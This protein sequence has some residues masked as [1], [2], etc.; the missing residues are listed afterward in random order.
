[1]SLVDANYI[2][3][4]IDISPIVNNVSKIIDELPKS[5]KDQLLFEFKKS[6]SNKNILRQ[7]EIMLEKDK[8]YGQL[9]KGD[10]KPKVTF[11]PESLRSYHEF[12]YE[13]LLEHKE[14]PSIGINRTFK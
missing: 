9:E 11:Q 12:R 6:Y 3:I 5:E 10:F 13:L 14:L 1:M 8:T 4:F 2:E 7:I